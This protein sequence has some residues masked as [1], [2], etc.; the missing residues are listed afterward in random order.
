MGPCKTGA[1]FAGRQ[2]DTVNPSKRRLVAFVAGTLMGNTGARMIYDHSSST[3][4]NYSG[5]VSSDR[6]FLLDLEK[7]CRIIGQ[8]NPAL[9]SLAYGPSTITLR[10]STDAMTFEGKDTE[11]NTSF[12][13]SVSGTL[14]LITDG[15]VGKDFIFSF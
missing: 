5:E 14:V 7:R 3:T 15:E 13:G 1:E 10:V 12:S 4:T 2:P 11:T 9:L 6:V 8:G